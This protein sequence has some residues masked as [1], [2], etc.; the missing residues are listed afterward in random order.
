MIYLALKKVFIIF[1]VIFSFFWCP[2]SSFAGYR[3]D[4]LVVWINLEKDHDAFDVDGVIVNFIRSGRIDLECGVDW[5]DG[6]SMLYMKKRPVGITNDLAWKVFLKKDKVALRH[7]NYLLKSF[8]DAENG[9][10]EGLDGVVIY[11]NKNGPHMMNLVAGKKKIKSYPL[12]SNNASLT[13]QDVEE[14]FCILLPPVTRA[15]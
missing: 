1:V 5:K 8:R 4:R 15:P 13:A 12:T 6:G 3:S 10:D 14:A 7:L 2:V 9:V 11:S